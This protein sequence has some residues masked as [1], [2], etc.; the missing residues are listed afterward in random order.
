MNLNGWHNFIIHAH[1]PPVQDIKPCIYVPFFK[2]RT[3]VDSSK[4]SGGHKRESGL[5]PWPFEKT[6][7]SW[8]L[9]NSGSSCTA[10]PQKGRNHFWHRWI[11]NAIIFWVS[12]DNS[13]SYKDIEFDHIK[14]CLTKCPSVV[15][16]QFCADPWAKVKYSSFCAPWW[17]A[18]RESVL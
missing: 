12:Q 11:W 6:S 9:C 7:I 15:A 16:F 3:S 5:V 2:S 14:D 4:N 10:G 17:G 1:F 18:L 13:T 8:L